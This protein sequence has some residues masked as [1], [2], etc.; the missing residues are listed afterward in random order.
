MIFLFFIVFIVCLDSTLTI[1]VESKGKNAEWDIF[2]S[3][4]QPIKDDFG[5]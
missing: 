1:G 5:N 2:T 3:S 4:P